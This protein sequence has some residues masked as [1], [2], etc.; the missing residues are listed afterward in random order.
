MLDSTRR[1]DIYFKSLIEIYQYITITNRHRCQIIVTTIAVAVIADILITAAAVSQDVLAKCK[2][3]SSSGNKQ[4]QSIAQANVCGNGNLPL[5]IKC[6]NLANQI[7]GD[8]NAVNV[9]GL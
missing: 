6:Q 1:S 7:Q 4:I 2:Y 8:G 3:H 5:N 9:I